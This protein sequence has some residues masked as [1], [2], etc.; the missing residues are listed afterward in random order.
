M[1]AVLINGIKNKIEGEDFFD[2]GAEAFMIDGLI[3]I[4]GGL[5]A[6]PIVDAVQKNQSAQCKTQIEQNVFYSTGLS[7][8]SANAFTVSRNNNEFYSEILGTAIKDANTSYCSIKYKIDK[9]LYK[10]I[11]EK[12]RL[13]FSDNQ[14]S[15]NNN[16]SKESIEAQRNILRKL[17]EVT[18]YEVIS[19]N[20]FADANKLNQNLEQMSKD[21]LYAVSGI[22]QVDMDEFESTASFTID[23][24]DITKKNNAV[25]KQITITQKLTDEI[26]ANPFKAYENYVNNPDTCE[27]IKKQVVNSNIIKIGN[28]NFELYNSSDP[29]MN[30]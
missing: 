27:I 22:G 14:T 5:A 24:V 19:T 20:F 3:I 4:F 26:K 29:T 30:I 11:L 6:M 1:L 13:D 12:V 10:D 21:S 15:G 2:D 7:H 16:I 23:F 25:A 17:V 8:F 28:E 9:Q 18:E